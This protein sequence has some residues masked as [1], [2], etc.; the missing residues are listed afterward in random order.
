LFRNP[1]FGAVEEF[2][3]LAGVPTSPLC[4]PLTGI[5]LYVTEEVLCGYFSS[6]LSMFEEISAAFDSH[7][8]KWYPISP[9]GDHD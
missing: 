1:I 3:E 2:L 4:S 8:E 5:D 7:R 6:A 9:R